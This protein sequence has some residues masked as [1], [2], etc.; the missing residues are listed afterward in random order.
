MIFAL[1]SLDIECKCFLWF[2]SF[3]LNVLAKLVAVVLF[4]FMSGLASAAITASV[5]TAKLSGPKPEA[6]GLTGFDL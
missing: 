2:R 5:L 4:T 3:D 1:L 6:G